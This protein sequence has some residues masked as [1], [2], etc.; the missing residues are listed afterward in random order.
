MR[1][2]GQG[3]VYGVSS[4][5]RVRAD[6]MGSGPCLRGQAEVMGQGWPYRVRAGLIGSG[7]G[8]QGQGR[9]YRVSAGL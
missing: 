4:F 8:L 6:F 9:V 5:Y 3:H 7:L 1:L 2:W